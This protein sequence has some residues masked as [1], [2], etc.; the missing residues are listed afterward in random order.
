[1]KAQDE[2]NIP[3]EELKYDLEDL[4]DLEDLDKKE[5]YRE[6]DLGYLKFDPRT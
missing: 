2:L 4:E 5:E 1:M 3:L 6:I